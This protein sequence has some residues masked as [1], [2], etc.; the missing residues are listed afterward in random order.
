[1]K[2]MRKFSLLVAIALI[3]TVGGVY[4]TWSYMD[5]SKVDRADANL[6]LHLIQY[7]VVGG[8]L[9]RYGS[10]NVTIVIDDNNNNHLAD[11]VTFEGSLV[12]VFTSLAG[13]NDESP[14]ELA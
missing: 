6:G 3:I 7:E 4:A 14:D 5:S 2:M 13:S 10:S 1:M 9:T 8:A 12:M 11:P